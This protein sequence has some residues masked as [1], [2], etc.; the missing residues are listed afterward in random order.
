MLSIVSLTLFNVIV[1][2]LPPPF[3]VSILELT[4]LPMVGR[5]TLLAA[6]AINV[7]AS[8]AFE[9]WGAPAVASV[10]GYLT[11]LRKRFRTR[12]GKT[13]KAVESGMR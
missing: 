9:R 6:T 7:G 5:L 4:D 11:D 13:Y 2:L 3:L 1:L 12:D 10:V 8:M